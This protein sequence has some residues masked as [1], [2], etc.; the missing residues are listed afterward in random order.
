MGEIQNNANPRGINLF[1]G[2]GC[3]VNAVPL[4]GCSANLVSTCS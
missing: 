2:C 3:T 4:C 1:P